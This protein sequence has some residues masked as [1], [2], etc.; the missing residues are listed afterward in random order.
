MLCR[1]LRSFMAKYGD[2]ELFP[3]KIQA[4][5]ML[6]VFAL[7]RFRQFATLEAGEAALDPGFYEVP[8]SYKKVS[9]EEMFGTSSMMGPKG[10]RRKEGHGAAAGQQ[11]QRGS[12]EFEAADFDMFGDYEF[13][14]S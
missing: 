5:L 2:R 9:A 11:Q 4:P 1:P 7:V 10:G 12:G 8:A 14:H 6:T 3:V 13:S